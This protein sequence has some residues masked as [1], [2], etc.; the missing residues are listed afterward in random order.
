M[1]LYTRLPLC[2]FLGF[3]FLAGL[4]RTCMINT[5]FFKIN[6][7]EFGK[8]K[9]FIFKYKLSLDS[10]RKDPVCVFS[11]HIFIK[12]KQGAIYILEN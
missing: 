5:S 9:S 1:I 10:L 2:K 12:T 11:V 6:Q 8:D 4:D 3:F 7:I